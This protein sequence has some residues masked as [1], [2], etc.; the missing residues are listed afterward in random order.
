VTG[1]ITAL[2]LDGQPDV[3]VLLKVLGSVVEQVGEQLK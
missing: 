2:L 1:S 3:T